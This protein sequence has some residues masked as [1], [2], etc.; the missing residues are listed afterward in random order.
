MA[1]SR[2]IVSG[3]DRWRGQAV[4]GSGSM[5]AQGMITYG[6]PFL[7]FLTVWQLFSHFYGIPDLFP[8]P[9]T[10]FQTLLSLLAD[11]SLLFDAGASL[12]RI[13]IG[14][15][16]GSVLGIFCGLLMGSSR[17]AHAA[18]NPY[19]NS[20]RFISA[21]AWISI[22]MIWF[23]IGEISKIS[24]IVYA[25]T[26]TVIV[27]TIAGV[28]AISINKIR[29]AFSFGAGAR[30]VFFWIKLPATVPYILSGIR[31]SLAN[32]YLV[33]VTAEMVQADSGMG[34]LIISARA[35]LAPD[36]IFTGIIVLGLLGLL[37]DRAFLLASHL[38]LSRYCQRG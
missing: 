15:A 21:I 28:K 35:Y 37:S 32:S 13:V 6:L 2:R 9:S 18:L 12:A 3:M 19:I 26:F 23:G 17:F 7:V 5:L 34:F 25:T 1:G 30:Q 11:G 33:I 29:A 31:L 24:V 4:A 10:T 27:N 20:L 22:F 16:I 14:L 36:I 38:C 8:P